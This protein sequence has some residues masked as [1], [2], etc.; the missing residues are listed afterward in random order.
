MEDSNPT[1]TPPQNMPNISGGSPKRR[2]LKV[3][4]IALMVLL[5]LGVIGTFVVFN[6]DDNVNNQNQSGGSL[7]Q[8]AATEPVKIIMTADEFSPATLLINVGTTVS[9]VN[10]DTEPFIV[11]SDPHPEHTDL[12]GLYSQEPIGPGDSYEHTFT[13]SGTYGYHNHLDPLQTGEV[14]VR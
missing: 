7:Q 4:A 9:W 13:E 10:Q 6:N 5:L 2:N 11:A 12:P 1:V 14:V 3:L 8:A